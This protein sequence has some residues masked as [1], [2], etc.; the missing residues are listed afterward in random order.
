MGGG[1]LRDVAVGDGVSNILS[2]PLIIGSAVCALA[3]AFCMAQGTV[4]APTQNRW[5][6]AG[7]CIGAASLALFAYGYGHL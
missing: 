5:L 2:V 6:L 7:V 3:G 1:N 4:V